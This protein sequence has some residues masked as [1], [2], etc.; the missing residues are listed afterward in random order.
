MPRADQRLKGAVRTLTDNRPY[1]VR[2][3]LLAFGAIGLAIAALTI[4]D[5]K[6]QTPPD[7]GEIYNANCAG[8]HG[9]DGAGNV[10]PALA[11]NADL[12]DANFVI[13]QILHGGQMMPPVGEGLTDDEV[14]AVINYIRSSWGNTATDTVTAD[15]VTAIRGG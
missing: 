12:G 1:V 7:G 13:G 2:A 14:A 11:G 10:G 9:Q 3:G 4:P 5:V 15:Q 8:C 6:A